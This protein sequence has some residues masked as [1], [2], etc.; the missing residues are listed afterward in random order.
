MVKQIGSGRT[1]NIS[2]RGVLFEGEPPLSERAEIVLEM[3][4]PF[5]LD[6]IRKLK[7]VVRGRIVRSD[8]KGT[9]VRFTNY[10]FRTSRRSVK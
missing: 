5:L 4:W 3:T 2:S 8:E 10:D 9:A 6:G 1:L 7:F